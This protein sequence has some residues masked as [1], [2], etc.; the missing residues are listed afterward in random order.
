MATFPCNFAKIRVRFVEICRIKYLNNNTIAPKVKKKYLDKVIK[1]VYIGSILA[2]YKP[3]CGDAREQG[4]KTEAD[5]N[6]PKRVRRA[7]CL[8][9]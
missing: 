5:G 4:D 3:E 8:L 2:G 1:L 7:I 6:K 9:P